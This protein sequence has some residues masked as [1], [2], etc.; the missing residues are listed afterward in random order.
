MPNKQLTLPLCLVLSHQYANPGEYTAMETTITR[1]YTVEEEDTGK[2]AWTFTLKHNSQD[3]IIDDLHVD[4]RE[5]PRGCFGHPKMITALLKGRI[6]HSISLNELA[7]AFCGHSLSCGQVLA[8]CLTD[9]SN[10]LA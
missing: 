8:Q 2:Y 6:L 4:E 3:W 9:L 10:E 5:K 7:E 1:T